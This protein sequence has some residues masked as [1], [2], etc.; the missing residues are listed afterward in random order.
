MGS[1]EAHIG[2]NKTIKGTKSK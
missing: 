2:C 1:I